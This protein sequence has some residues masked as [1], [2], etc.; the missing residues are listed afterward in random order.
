LSFFFNNINILYSIEQ[1]SLLILVLDVSINEEGVGFGMNVFHGHLKAIEASSFWDLHLGAE[2]L[3][4]VLHDDSVTCGEKCK[5]ILD[6]MFLIGVKFI[7][8]L[9]ILVEID[10]ISCPEGS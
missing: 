3:C 10:L 1:I 2:L 9:E 4:E 8:I 5:H 6:E 7:P